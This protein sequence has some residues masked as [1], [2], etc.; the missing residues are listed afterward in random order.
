MTEASKGPMKADPL[1]HLGEILTR[2]ENLI[3]SMMES[4]V[5][6][7]TVI[8]SKGADPTEFYNAVQKSVNDW[9]QYLEWKNDVMVKHGRE[10]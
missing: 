8:E 3:L 2:H 6:A 5:A 9:N 7:A 4:L 1:P 10:K